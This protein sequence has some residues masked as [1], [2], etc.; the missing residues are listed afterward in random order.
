MRKTAPYSQL[1][2]QVSQTHHT[3]GLQTWVAGGNPSRCHHAIAI[4]LQQKSFIIIII[5]NNIIRLYNIAGSTKYVIDEYKK[6]GDM[7][8]MLKEC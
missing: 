8:A 3:E 4:G 7:Q 2:P 5:I 1:L 6:T